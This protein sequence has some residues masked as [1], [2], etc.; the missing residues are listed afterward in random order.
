MQAD[1]GAIARLEEMGFSRE[2]C[3]LALDKTHGNETAAID[4]LLETMDQPIS[5][6]PSAFDVDLTAPN[7]DDS[8]IK[9]GSDYWPP[10]GKPITPPTSPDLFPIDLT[11]SPTHT[12]RL[13][14]NGPF[15]PLTAGKSFLSAEELE[16]NRALEMSLNTTELD[17]YGGVGGT[18]RNFG[19]Q[20]MEESAMEDAIT[21]SLHDVVKSVGPSDLNATTPTYTSA[22]E[23]L[24]ELENRVRSANTSV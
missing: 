7:P 4:H 23:G 14:E 18:D 15:D 20:S 22:V 17:A 21:R 13:I 8:R 2:R 9:I 6:D 5:I 10:G 24:L 19:T 1:A 16:I 11:N 12:P 3:K